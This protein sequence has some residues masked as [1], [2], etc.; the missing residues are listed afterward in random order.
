V[1]GKSLSGTFDPA[2]GLLANGSGFR[3][4]LLDLPGF[5]ADGRHVFIKG[6][7]GAL[8]SRA[9]GARDFIVCDG[10]EGPSHDG[11]WIPDEF[12]NHA[13]R[14]RYVVRDD[15]RLR[16]MEWAWP[17]DRTWQ[18]AVEQDDSAKTQ[19]KEQRL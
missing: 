6:F 5:S 12:K 13:K 15:D 8:E 4:V 16:L 17:K 9:Q 14:L 10:I 19:A 18:D 3:M 2:A 7:R 11:L 1:D